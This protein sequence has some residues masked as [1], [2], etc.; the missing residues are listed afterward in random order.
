MS[1]IFSATVCPLHCIFDHARAEKGQNDR[2]FHLRADGHK[3]TKEKASHLAFPALSSYYL[4]IPSHPVIPMRG[5]PAPALQGSPHPPGSSTFLALSATSIQYFILLLFHPLS[6]PLC[7]ICT[8][9]CSDVRG[10]TIYRIL[11]EGNSDAQMWRSTL[12]P[13]RPRL[14]QLAGSASRPFLCPV[15]GAQ[16]VSDHLSRDRPIV[17]LTFPGHFCLSLIILFI[18]LFFLSV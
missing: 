2:P 5:P 12:S 17:N 11:V 16:I 15:D 18:I 4:T 9:S 14:Q 7:G 1:A 6:D 13:Q 8:I 3:A 10:V